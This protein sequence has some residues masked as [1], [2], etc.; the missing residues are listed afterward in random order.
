M[1]LKLSLPHGSTLVLVVGVALGGLYLANKLNSALVTANNTVTAENEAILRQSAAF[2][3][4]VAGYDSS[5]KSYDKRIASLKRQLPAIEQEL[6]LSITPH[7]TI[8]ALAHR[9]LVMD[10]ACSLLDSTYTACKAEN[11]ILRDRNEILE[12]ALERQID[13]GQCHILFMGCPSRFTIAEI[14]TVIGGTVGFYLGKH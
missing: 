14:F 4:K 8:A 10:S 2:K 9:I 13:V 12:V 1:N 6:A 3:L 5:M 11:I 7:D